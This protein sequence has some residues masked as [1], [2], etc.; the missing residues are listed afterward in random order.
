VV[1]ISEVDLDEICQIR[2]LLEVPSTVEVART[3]V[4]EVMDE[5][6]VI[7]DDLVAAAARGDLVDYLDLD[8]RFHSLLISQLNNDR[9]TDLVDRTRRQTRL[10]GLVA[11][12]ESGVLVTSAQGHHELI[13]PMRGRD[14]TA[15][16][17]VINSHIKHIRGLWVGREEKW[18]QPAG[19][20]PSCGATVTVVCTDGH[21]T[22]AVSP[23]YA[24]KG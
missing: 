21:R 14:T 6:S 17:R 11:L 22:S 12:A 7:A 3:I 8:R 5:L 20:Y 24:P 9:L 4:P 16:E 19:R 2:L 15:T 13:E 18:P 1:E 23:A 10:F